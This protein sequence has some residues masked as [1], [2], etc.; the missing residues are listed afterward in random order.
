MTL[1]F[2][3]K[4]SPSAC[5]CDS[6]KPWLRPSVVPGPEGGEDLLVVLGEGGVGDQQQRHV[7]FADHVVHLAQRAVLLGEADRRGLL[8]RGR[9]LAQADLDPDA[10]A[11]Q[12][13]AQVLRLGR[14]LR[15][16]ADDADLLDAVEGL[17]QQR[18]Q[19]AAAGDDGFLAVGHLDDAGFEHLG[20]ET[21]RPNPRSANGCSCGPRRRARAERVKHARE[22]VSKYAAR[23]NE[24]ATT[25]LQP[26]VRNHGV[27]TH[28]RDQCLG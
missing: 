8:H 21:H 14:A 23:S 20:G 19:V 16:P 27:A 17:G 12:R 3:G 2:L 25:A 10:G 28:C 9:A 11:F 4:S 26:A 7:A 1:M 24:T 13:F 15:R 22:A 6:R 18:E 5:R